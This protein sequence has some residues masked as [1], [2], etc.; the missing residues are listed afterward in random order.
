MPTPPAVGRQRTPILA[1]ALAALALAGCGNGAKSGRFCSPAPVSMT[2]DVQHLDAAAFGGCDTL[3]V[4]V[5]ALGPTERLAVVLLNQG[6]PDH[7][8]AT[9]TVNGTG[10]PP[11]ARVDPTLLADLHLD[12]VLAPGLEAQASRAAAHD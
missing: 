11:P 10:A 8:T 1:A 7:T 2:G 6:G 4:Q 9:V 5:P 3:T 12:T